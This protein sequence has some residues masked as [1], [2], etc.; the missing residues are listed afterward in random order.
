M[1]RKSKSR[2]AAKERRSLGNVQ[3]SRPAFI[4]G[5]LAAGPP[6]SAPKRTQRNL[7]S[8]A[9]SAQGEEVH[10]GDSSNV[11]VGSP[12]R[13]ATFSSAIHALL[14]LA[15]EQGQVSDDDVL[16]LLPEGVSPH[17]LDELYTRLKSLGVKISDDAEVQNAKQEEV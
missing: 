5:A 7:A 9:F 6:R 3:R 1:K 4:F 13:L 8:A 14:G 10:T 2:E 17:D 12:E 11:A 15:R 16:E